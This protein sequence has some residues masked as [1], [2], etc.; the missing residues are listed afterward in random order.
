MKK[1][2][3]I[4]ILLSLT[5]CAVHTQMGLSEEEWN[6]LSKEERVEL[7]M[8]HREMRIK[9][10][11]A[12][13][14][15]QRLNNEAK[16][17]EVLLASSVAAS[18]AAAAAANKTDSNITINNSSNSNSAANNSST[19]TNMNDSSNTNTNNQ[20][21]SNDNSASSDNNA[22]NDL[23]NE[24]N[25]Q[26]GDARCHG[27]STNAVV[28]YKKNEMHNCGYTGDLWSDS[29]K[30]HYEYC[31]SEGFNAAK[32]QKRERRQLIKECKNQEEQDS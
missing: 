20:N 13:A 14:E 19:N 32:T 25:Y 10:R 22:S 23:N 21:Q 24:M 3:L 29:Y 1:L 8:R 9:E 11:K 5:S 16:R 18:N 15:Q 30:Y 17:Q 31:M 26:L 12:W 6:A 28:Q 27:Y 7:T 2:S 4:A